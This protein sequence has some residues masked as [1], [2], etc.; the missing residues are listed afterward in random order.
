MREILF[1]KALRESNAYHAF[2]K[3]LESGIGHAYAIIS[4]DDEIVE[5]FFSLLATTLSCETNSACLECPACRRTLDGNNPDISCIFPAGAYLKVDQIK[6]IVQDVYVTPIGERKLYFIHRADLMTPEAQNKFLKT[7]EEPPANVIFFLGTANEYRLIDTVRSRCRAIYIEPFS[8]EAVCLG[9]RNLGYSNETSAIAASYCDG[10]P[11]KAKEFA[12]SPKISATYTEA[13]DLLYNLKRSP[14]VLACSNSPTL[15]KDP[16]FFL[17]ILSTVMKDVSL[18]KRNERSLA[19]PAILERLKDVAATF[20][21]RA[22][23]LSE[24]AVILALEELYYHIDP[25]SVIDKLL[26]S[27]LEVKHKWQP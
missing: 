2:L 22:L 7:L 8:R 27:I 6:E 16:K 11:G 9:L 12:D 1:D 10:M 19:S 23:A 13:L 15:K 3:S 5:E 4:S 18:V 20:S 25:V 21:L 14:N 26:F 24:E 17:P